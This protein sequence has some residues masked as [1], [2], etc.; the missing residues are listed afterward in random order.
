VADPA[1][2][3]LRTADGRTL[4]YVD[5]GP[6]DGYPVFSLHGAPGCRLSVRGVDQIRSLGCRLVTYDRPGNGRSDRRPGRDASDCVSDVEAVADALGLRE[7]AVVGGSA[8]SH[9]ALAVAARLPSRVSRAAALGAIA[10]LEVLGW[11][12]SSRLQDEETIHYLR[13]CAKG[14]EAAAAFLGEM[15]AEMRTAADPNT[16]EGAAVLEQTRNGVWGWVDDELACQIPWGFDPAEVTA[17]AAIW[18]NPHDTVTPPNHAEWL[19][20]AMPS[21]FLVS[22]DNAP[23]HAEIAD[24]NAARSELYSWL[25][26]GGR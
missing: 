26:E 22:S 23:G 24:P 2:Q 15:D 21:A 8:G 4:C 13:I 7:F 9:H 6:A 3:M 5:W 25:L 18:S 16:V 12:E 20:D 11:D 14:G 17:P 1:A 10:P 19:V